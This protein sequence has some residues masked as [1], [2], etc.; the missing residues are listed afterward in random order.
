[1]HTSDKRQW[2]ALMVKTAWEIT[3]LFPFAHCKNGVW[4]LNTR[5]II[6]VYRN[7]FKR[8]SS[9]HVTK[10]N[11]LSFLTPVPMAF[12]IQTHITDKHKNRLNMWTKWVQAKCLENVLN[13][14]HQVYS[15]HDL[16]VHMV[17]TSNHV[18]LKTQKLHLTMSVLQALGILQAYFWLFDNL[19]RS[20]TYKV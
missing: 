10:L 8:P 4:N 17:Q 16:V 2:H 9:V 15:V 20:F 12:S 5:K 3:A 19:D 11:L 6:R 1:M 18:F 13:S 7:A 14:K